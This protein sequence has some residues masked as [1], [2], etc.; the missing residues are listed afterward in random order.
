MF[1]KHIWFTQA[2]SSS[3][4]S[5]KGCLSGEAK[6]DYEL[7]LLVLFPFVYL[8]KIVSIVDY[9]VDE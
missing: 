3:S 8:V 5:G 2:E 9:G 4:H 1:S 6:G 7:L